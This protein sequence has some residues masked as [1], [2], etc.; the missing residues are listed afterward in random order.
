MTHHCPQPQGT[1]ASLTDFPKSHHTLTQTQLIDLVSVSHLSPAGL[2][3]HN[4]AMWFITQALE[5]SNAQGEP[6][7]HNILEVCLT[8]KDSVHL[9]GPHP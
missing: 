9:S 5:V 6:Q 8:L 2:W 3:L 4:S 7:I 1:A